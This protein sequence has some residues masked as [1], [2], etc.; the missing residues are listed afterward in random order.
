MGH[1][2]EASSRVHENYGTMRPPDQFVQYMSDIAGVIADH[3]YFEE[4]D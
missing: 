3:G 4:Y 1:K 2:T